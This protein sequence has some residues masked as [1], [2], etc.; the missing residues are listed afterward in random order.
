M[1]ET[2]RVKVISTDS[3]GVMSTNII[4]VPNNVIVRASQNA[5]DSLAEVFVGFHSGYNSWVS[6]YSYERETP[7]RNSDLDFIIP[8]DRNG[9]VYGEYNKYHQMSFAPAEPELTEAQAVP[10]MS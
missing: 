8:C 3:A 6:G 1:S 5:R 10:G 7:G 2:T 4:A 9:L